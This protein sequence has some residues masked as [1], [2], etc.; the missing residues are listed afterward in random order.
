[1]A[2]PISETPD[3]EGKAAEAVL[4]RMRD[5]PTKKD[6]EFG[7]KLSKLYSEREVHLE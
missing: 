6:I 2:K 3:L 7:K 1:M 4:Q 5:P